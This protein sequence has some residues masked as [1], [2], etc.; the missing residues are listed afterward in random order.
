PTF[1]LSRRSSRSSR[2]FD[3]MM[4]FIELAMRPAE[5][6][7]VTGRRAE[8]SPRLTAVRTLSMTRGSTTLVATTL[9]AMCW[10]SSPLL[11]PRASPNSLVEGHPELDACS[12]PWLALDPTPTSRHQRPFSNGRQA[13]VAWHV[14]RL[15]ND[16]AGAVVD[17]Q[18]ADAAIDRLRRQLD[19]GGVCVLFHV[20]Q[21]FGHVLEDD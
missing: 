5:P 11:R 7:H 16:E 20:G 17:H 2:W 14:R 12:C 15:L 4:S 8:K 18:N 6:V 9:V 13:E 1:L 10:G 3:S 21:G 19:R